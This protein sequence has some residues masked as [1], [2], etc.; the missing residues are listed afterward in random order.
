[1]ELYADGATSDV[2]NGQF[3][4][5]VLAGNATGSALVEDSAALFSIEG[6][7]NATGNLVPGTSNEPTWTSKTHLIRIRA[8]G[9]VMYIPAVEL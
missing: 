1:M 8:N 7:T 2:A 3:M 5:C 6:G 4:R 9:T